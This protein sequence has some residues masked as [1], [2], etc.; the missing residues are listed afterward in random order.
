VSARSAL[1]GGLGSLA[2]FLIHPMVQLDIGAMQGVHRLSEVQGCE[3]EQG[4][5]DCCCR[6]EQIRSIQALES[7]LNVATRSVS[8]RFLYEEL[9]AEEKIRRYR[10]SK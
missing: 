6:C 9:E 10:I 5:K 1:T 7:V 3:P 2:F 8:K 4:L